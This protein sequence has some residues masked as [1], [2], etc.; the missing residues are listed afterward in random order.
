MM[1]HR[2]KLLKM[3]SVRKQAARVRVGQ[4]KHLSGETNQINQTRDPTTN[5]NQNDTSHSTKPVSSF[6]HHSAV[7]IAAS[8]PSMR[9]TPATMLYAGKSPDRSHLLRSAQYLHKELPV[10]IAHRIA[11]FRGLPFIVGCNP[12]ILQVH[13]MYIRAFQLLIEHPRITDFHMERNYTELLKKLLD[14]HRDVVTMLADGFRECRKHIQNEQLV[15]QFLDRTLTS[16]LGLRMLAEHHLALHDDK[17]N[18]VGII[19]VNLQ[20]KK[21]IENW[22]DFATKVCEHRYGRAPAINLNGH[23]GATFPYIEQPLHYILPEILKNAMRATVEKNADAS[24]LPPVTVT[25]ASND[26]DFIIRVSDR[27]GGIPHQF[28]ERIFDYHFTTAGVQEENDDNYDVFGAMVEMSN[29]SPGSGP[30]HGFGFGLPTSR[31]Y[32]EY[33]GGSLKVEAMQGIG[34]DVYLRLRHI[35]GKHESFRI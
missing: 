31:A 16:R 22:A 21:V 7:D 26:V 15:R 5:A 24:T 3:V 1:M 2:D 34:T 10:R 11:G 17:S 35:E 28:V 6:Y 14:D 20:L 23:S 29:P 30:M 32:A 25:I 19:C 12:T 13:E 9:L 8:K 33:L 4:V 27:G 18:Y